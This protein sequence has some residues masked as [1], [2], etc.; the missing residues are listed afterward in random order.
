MSA[1]D[2]IDFYGESD[3]RDVAGKFDTVDVINVFADFATD[4]AIAIHLLGSVRRQFVPV[5]QIAKNSEVRKPG[6]V[7]VLRIPRWLADARGLNWTDDVL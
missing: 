4:K 7:G 6:D 3:D 2:Y 1:E 5:S